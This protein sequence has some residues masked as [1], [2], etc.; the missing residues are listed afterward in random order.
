M[1][2]IA[3][4]CAA[5]VIYIISFVLF[6]TATARIQPM[7]GRHPFQVTRLLVTNPRWVAGCVLLTSGF[8]LSGMAMLD[9]PPATALPAYGI[10][11]GLLLVVARR[12]F[13]ERPTSREWLAA[14][15]TIAAMIAIALSIGPEPEGAGA[16]YVVG[17]EPLWEIAVVVV[18][19]L[20]IP[21]YMFSV[22][23]RLDEGRH[24]IPLTGIAYGVGAGV[25]LGTAE[26]F[27]LGMARML[28]EHRFDVHLS[29]YPYVFLIAGPLG[30]GL[31][32]IGLQ[33]CRLSVLVTVVTLTAK[34]HLL[35]SASLLY[36]DPWPQDPALFGLRVAGVGLAVVALMTFP[37]HERTMRVPHYRM[38]T[39]IMK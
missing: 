5:Q 29:P 35:L 12:G 24:A 37:R 3:L 23:D 10:S 25:L 16:S 39:P 33:R 18:P 2:A 22:R 8:A 20:L 4:A 6:K 28:D 15:I 1:E 7:T 31:T 30:L 34:V 19:S 14:F 38:R 36:G 27:G 21:L 11:L 13:D 9:L 32:S 17:G 26:V